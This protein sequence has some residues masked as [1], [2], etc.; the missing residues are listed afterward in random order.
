[1]RFDGSAWLAAQEDGVVYVGKVAYQYKG[2]MPANYTLTLREDTLSIAEWAFN[3]DQSLKSV[4]IPDSVV[5]I[6]RYAFQN[7]MQME[8]LAIGNGV[9][10]IGTSAFFSCQALTEVTVPASVN[11]LRPNSFAD[12]LSLTALRFQCTVEEL[13]AIVREDVSWYLGCNKDLVITCKDGRFQ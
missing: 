6:D 3:S 9:Q 13:R 10:K 4:T 8:T 2:T 11:I 7:C 1:M 12:C 5:L